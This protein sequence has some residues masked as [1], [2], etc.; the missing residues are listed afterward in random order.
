MRKGSGAG[1]LSERIRFLEPDKVDDGY[2]GTTI[3]YVE[4]FVEPARMQPR[5]GGETVQASRLAGLQ[6]FTMTVRS[7]VRTRAVTPQWR[8]VNVRTGV[9]YNIKAAVNIDERNQWIELL[10]AAG[11]A[12]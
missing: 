7:S 4:R 12:G 8:A 2:G 11:E 5:V 6:P 1:S 10:V 9:G 3:G